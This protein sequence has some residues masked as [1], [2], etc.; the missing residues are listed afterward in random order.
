MKL[1]IRSVSEV[2]SYVYL[3]LLKWQILVHEINHG[4][5]LSKSESELGGHGGEIFSTLDSEKLSKCP[6]KPDEKNP[7][8]AEA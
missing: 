1:L 5:G 7:N 4:P 2:F 6:L 3:T 8:L